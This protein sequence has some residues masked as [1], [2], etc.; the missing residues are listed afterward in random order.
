VFVRCDRGIQV[1]NSAD[2]RVYN[3]TFVDSPALF[4]R[5]E[6]SAVADH[7][8]WHPST[9]PDVEQREGHVFVNNLMVA[10]DGFRGALARFVQSAGLCSR[11]TR[12]E[13]KEVNGNVYVRPVPAV[14]PAAAVPLVEWAPVPGGASC[15]AAPSSVEEFQKVAAGY[16]AAGKQM[17]RT[18]RS[19]FKGFDVGRYELREAIPAG[20][21]TPADVRKVL[22]WSEADAKTAG[23]FPA[24]K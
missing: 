16:E 9:G 11:L 4:D 1:L 2:V 20:A 7:F 21:V 14:A 19:V 15:Q 8:G 3:N 18:P 13:A 12:P 22:G 10:S 5:N 24:K 23:A 17:D 6:R